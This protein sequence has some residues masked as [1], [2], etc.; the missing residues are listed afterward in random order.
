MSSNMMDGHTPPP[1]AAHPPDDA[2]F[3]YVEG[4]AGP[5]VRDHVE[6]HLATCMEC[7]G[8]VAAARAA[9]CVTGI[10]AGRLVAPL[11]EN[12][13]ARLATV[14]DTEWQRQQ[15]R[16]SRA[17]AGRRSRR[18]PSMRWLAGGIASTAAA[19]AIVLVIVRDLP[20]SATVPTSPR[21]APTV[22]TDSVKSASA[23]ATTAS[24]QAAAPAATNAATASDATATAPTT[25][26]QPT[27][28]G[29]AADLD[30]THPRCVLFTTGEKSGRA[31]LEQA[32]YAGITWRTA[33]VLP[34]IGFACGTPPAPPDASGAWTVTEDEPAA[35][36]EQGRPGT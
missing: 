25:A 3:D 21:V 12:V 10:D 13:A 16:T 6:Q 22:S 31:A 2:L 15:P 8:A 30:S 7:A 4:T 28:I 26:P 24:P 32:G 34:S 14:I 36:A 35:P 33:G 9:T 1:G 20:P 27:E 29:T 5:A 11:P 23:E 19:A 18:L 17:A